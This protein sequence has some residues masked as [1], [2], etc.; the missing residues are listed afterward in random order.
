MAVSTINYTKFILV[1]NWPGV[2]VTVAD[3]P[4]DGFTGSEHHNVTSPVFPIGT[5]MQV[6]CDGS[7]GT[8][9]QATFVYLKLGT[10]D[11][12]A[13][14]AK[15]VV[16]QDSATNWYEVTNDPDS[17][18]SLPTGLAAV[19]LTAMTNDTYGWFWCGGVC[20]KQYVAALTDDFATDAALEAGPFTAH[21]L[22]SGVVGFGPMMVEGTSSTVLAETLFGYSLA[23]DA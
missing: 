2:P 17:C 4:K 6:F 7:A 12:T 16:V 5:K 14:A 9:G 18:I 8:T 3:V 21:S 13:V 10:Q 23:Q 15:S 1:D 20:P 19:A 22:T 11:A